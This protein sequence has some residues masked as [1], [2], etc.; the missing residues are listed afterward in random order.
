MALCCSF[1]TQT[2][3]GTCVCVFV[4]YCTDFAASVYNLVLKGK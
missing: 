1:I 3:F 2:A 4:I